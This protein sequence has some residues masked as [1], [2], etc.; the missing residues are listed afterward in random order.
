MRETACTHGT[1]STLFLAHYSRQSTLAND[2]RERERRA[3]RTQKEERK[4][5]MPCQMYLN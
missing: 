2:E 5:G 1:G 3:S 4:R